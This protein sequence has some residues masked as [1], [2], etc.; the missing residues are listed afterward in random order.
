MQRHFRRHILHNQHWEK[1]VR[2]REQQEASQ[3]ILDNLHSSLDIP[4]YLFQWKTMRSSGAGGQHVNT[5]ESR[6]ELRISIDAD[7]FTK[8]LPPYLK[9][10][11]LTNELIHGRRTS[12]EWILSCQEH[13]SQLKNRQV[14]VEK[15]FLALKHLAQSTIPPERNGEKDLA[16]ARRVDKLASSF[17]TARLDH[18]K[19]HSLRKSGRRPPSID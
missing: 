4:S 6:V 17:N 13:R 1:F 14:C 8:W 10:Q 3:W 9:Q 16:Q 7:T 2:T 11:L 5:T 15:M 12:N 19:H 18:K